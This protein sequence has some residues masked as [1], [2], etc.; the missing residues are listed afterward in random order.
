MSTDGVRKSKLCETFS[1]IS[2][3]ICL[4]AIGLLRI[5][6]IVRKDYVI[7]AVVPIILALYVAQIEM[8]LLV[9]LDLEHNIMIAVLISFAFINRTIHSRFVLILTW[10]T[11]IW[12]LSLNLRLLQRNGPIFKLALAT[13]EEISQINKTFIL[14]LN[15]HY[16]LYGIPVFT[17]IWSIY[18]Y[19]DEIHRKTTFLVL[20][21]RIKEF[22]FLKTLMHRLVPESIRKYADV[23]SNS[24]AV[25][26]LSNFTIIIV[27]LKNYDSLFSNLNQ[28]DQI[29]VYKTMLLIQK[30]IQKVAQRHGVFLLNSIGERFECVCGVKAF[31]K[32]I[33]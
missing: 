1:S 19:W 5:N 24:S 25:D 14:N 10:A 33:S 12:C 2:L 26:L 6:S 31:E 21:R 9:S 18:I 16:Y 23:R 11:S 13:N 27:K 30:S 17:L 32:N 29:Q 28:S 20:N 22:K 3:V 7:F 8:A 4:I 15:T